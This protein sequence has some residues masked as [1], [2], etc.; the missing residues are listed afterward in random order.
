M[1]INYDVKIN[2]TIQ[3]KRITTKTLKIDNNSQ[4]GNAMTKPLT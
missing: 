1:Q 4:Y 2:N 3:E